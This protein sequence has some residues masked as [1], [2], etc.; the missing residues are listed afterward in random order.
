[1][2]GQCIPYRWTCDREEDCPDGSD[3]S[4][5]VCSERQCSNDEWS[6]HVSD[7]G[8]C[9]PLSWVCDSHHDCQD[10][11][12][13]SVCT[14]TCLS[15]EF[16]CAS[17]LCIQPAWRCDGEDDCGDGSDE[18]GCA[19][20]VC[21]RGEVQ[22]RGGRC[23]KNRHVCDGE[24]DCED[25]G[26][27]VGCDDTKHVDNTT[28]V[29]KADEFSCDE[30]NF[31]VHQSW[32]CDGDRDCPDGS[33]ESQEVCKEGAACEGFSCG[34]GQ[35]IPWRYYCDGKSHCKDGSDEKN[36]TD[37]VISEKK[38]DDDD[39]NPEADPCHT[40]PPVCS[41]IC[42]STPSRLYKCECQSGYTKDL[43]NKSQCK[44]MEGHPSLLFAHKTDIRKLSLDRPSMTSIVNN[45]R[46]SC[47]VDYD[48]K[49]G[50]VFWSDV[51]EEKIY[52]APID[53]GYS[54]SVVVSSGVVDGLAVD[55]VYSH[56][57]W[58]DTHTDTISVTDMT[59][60]SRAVLV[61]DK[62]EEPR[63][64]A[65][66]P[67][68]GWMFWSDWGRSPCIERAGMDGSHRQV[69]LKD[70]VRWPNGLTVDLVLE[71]LYWVDA[72][73]NTIGSS[74]LDGSHSR[75][76]LLST[77][78]L[79]HPFSISV[80]SDLVY[81][82]EWD[83]HA[84][85][86]ADKFTGSNITALTTTDSTQLPMVVQVYHPYR[87]PDY[88]NHC[89]PFNG[90]CSHFCLAAPQVTPQSSPTACQCPQY[91]QLDRDNRTCREKDSVVPDTDTLASTPQVSDTV[92]VYSITSMATIVL[93][94]ILL[95][96]IV[97]VVICLYR[98]SSSPMISLDN[99]E[100]KGRD[101]PTNSVQRTLLTLAVRQDRGETQQL[102]QHQ[103]EPS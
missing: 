98:Q 81:W 87:Q 50:M 77:Q 10:G 37:S 76:I 12:D 29:C 83:T 99:R 48:F 89:L 47:A 68:L 91:L 39:K 18:E 43:H 69:I 54:Q 13:E 19:A 8:Q 92:R 36:C 75:T 15:E 90:H 65:L 66:H 55:W 102:L 3:E 53:S 74:N 45:T 9:I 38:V 86:Q 42:T 5:S 32:T 62:L 46:S 59:G 58:T 97:Q 57:Y 96:S 71:K 23:V 24:A 49:T 67:G 11:S 88:P 79:R 33:D 28:E 26:D 60:L 52:K 82:T 72:K 1:V 30:H 64:I 80:F 93:S 34:G 16:T 44:A 85:Y 6:C 78:H 41:Q 4:P 61:R 63:A 70:K 20:I 84:I 35:C 17:G 95:A 103:H 56:L 27:E 51:M 73:L 25:G 31:C 22:C 21:A 40:W 14:T 101:S 2:S 100:A 94:I 7:P